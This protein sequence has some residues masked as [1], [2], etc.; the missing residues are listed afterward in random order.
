MI[1]VYPFSK[2]DETTVDLWCDAYG[3]PPQGSDRPH[4]GFMSFCTGI[5]TAAGFLRRAEGDLGIIEGLIASPESRGRIRSNAV[6]AVIDEILG[7]ASVH[8][9]KRIMATTSNPAVIER[10][11]KY[12]FKQSEQVLIVRG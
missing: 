6:N 1:T 4:I 5:P 12:G 10:A 7:A 3:I 9:I 11:K 2:E 8:G